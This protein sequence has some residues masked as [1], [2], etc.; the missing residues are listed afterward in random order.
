MPEILGGK[1]AIKKTRPEESRH[2]NHPKAC[3]LRI[4]CKK[5]SLRFAHGQKSPNR[6]KDGHKLQKVHAEVRTEVHIRM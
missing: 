6:K 3:E 5:M 2:Y 4:N 1:Q